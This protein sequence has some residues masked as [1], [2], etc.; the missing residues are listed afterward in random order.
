MN[1]NLNSL[2][3]IFL[4]VLAGFSPLIIAFLMP[5]INGIYFSNIYFSNISEIILISAFLRFGQD[6]VLLKSESSFDNLVSIVY[7]QIFNFLIILFFSFFFSLD[8]IIIPTSFI[9]TIN[10]IVASYYLSRD[11]RTISVL[12]QFLIPSLLIILIFS[13]FQIKISEIYI[14]IL[15]SYFFPI[16][17]LFLKISKKIFDD[18][19]IIKYKIEITNLN[20]L[21]YTILSISISTIPIIISEKYFSADNTILLFQLMKFISISSFLS[22]L[23]IFSFNTNLRNLNSNLFINYLKRYALLLFIGLNFCVYLAHYLNLFQ[24]QFSFQIVLPFI[25]LIIFYSNIIGHYFIL[26]SAE[27]YNLY[28]IVLSCLLLFI[29]YILLKFY[30][31]NGVLIIFFYISLL[32]AEALLKLFF[33][34]RI[35]KIF[36][37]E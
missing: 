31:F 5:K 4:R 13:I 36:G 33:F 8:K 11:K 34:F 9:Y 28:A 22:S 27:K 29:Y 16:F 1:L 12:I 7:V 17:F 20:I 19:K 2:L 24:L 32:L 15:F 37:N 30:N 14:V 23:F 35:Y 18:F 25:M 26:K 6:M 21:L 10:S 3:A